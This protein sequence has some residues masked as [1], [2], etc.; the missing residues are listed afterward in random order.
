MVKHKQIKETAQNY[1]WSA[2]KPCKIIP[3]SEQADSYEEIRIFRNI[4]KCHIF[5]FLKQYSMSL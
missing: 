3:L 5:K 2:R 1:D 4:T